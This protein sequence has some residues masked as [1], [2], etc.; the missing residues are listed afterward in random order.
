M[1]GNEKLV[2][3]GIPAPTE[4]MRSLAVQ[5]QKL[6][7]DELCVFPSLNRAV[8]EQAATD[9]ANEAARS[10]LIHAA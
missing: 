2:S 8:I 4:A 1:T 6:I 3:M 7:Y 10:H 9:G 5:V